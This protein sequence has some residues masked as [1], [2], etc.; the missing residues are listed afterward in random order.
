MMKV[1]IDT[2]DDLK[3]INRL[4]EN[5]DENDDVQNVFHNIENI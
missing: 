1:T 4:M 3:I 2:E 5:L